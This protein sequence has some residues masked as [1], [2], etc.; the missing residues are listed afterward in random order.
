MSSM[1]RGSLEIWQIGRG[2]YSNFG[3]GVGYEQICSW[4]RPVTPSGHSTFWSCFNMSVIFSLQRSGDSM[5]LTVK[6]RSRWRG[7]NSPTHAAVASNYVKASKSSNAIKCAKYRENL[8]RKGSHSLQKEVKAQ[9][10]RTYRANLSADIRAL[11][12][13]GARERM[14]KYRARRKQHQKEKEQAEES[15]AGWNSPP[16]SKLPLWTRKLCQKL[17]H[18]HPLREVFQLKCHCHHQCLKQHRSTLKLYPLSRLAEIHTLYWS[19]AGLSFMRW[20]RFIYGGM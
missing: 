13:A 12:N 17:H 3:K 5:P 1:G 8:K 18:C 14:Q 4:G 6:L 11:S 2:V 7:Q 19:G 16:W 20:P 10:M 9:Y 15:N